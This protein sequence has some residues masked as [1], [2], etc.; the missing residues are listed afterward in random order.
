[1]D[2]P[3]DEVQADGFAPMDQSNGEEKTRLGRT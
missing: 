1:M 3:G 2:Y